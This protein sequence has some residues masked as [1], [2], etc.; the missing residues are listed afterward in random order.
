MIDP[1]LSPDGLFLAWLTR[2]NG[3][4]IIYDITTGE[5]T[6]LQAPNGVQDFRWGGA[7]GKKFNEL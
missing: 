2:P 4:L 1:V 7:E 6:L 3:L 5:R